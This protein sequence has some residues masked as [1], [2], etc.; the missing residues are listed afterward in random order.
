M[1]IDP[2]A[3]RVGLALSDGDLALPHQTVEVGRDPV[4]KLAARL[5][6][7]VRETSVDEV[8]VGLPLN[9]DGSEGRSAR[10]A[11]DLADALAASVGAK[12]VLWDERLTTA[13]AERALLDGGVSGRKRRKVVDQ[14]AATHILQSY[15]DAQRQTSWQD[16]EELPSVP[17][18]DRR[19]RKKDR[20]GRRR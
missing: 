19:G 4:S 1:G 7:T 3:A 17:V 2:G 16:D 10:R 6:D 11:R 12:V 8:I 20:G 15:L 9:M 13:S 14:V 18:P 5:A